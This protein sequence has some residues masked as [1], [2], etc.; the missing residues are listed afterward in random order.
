MARTNY[1]NLPQM[2]PGT[3][4][5]RFTDSTS[6]PLLQKPPINSP[7]ADKRGFNASYE[8]Q[9]WFQT[10]V[11]AVREIQ[12]IT[13]LAQGGP[14]G[15]TGIQGLLGERGFTGLGGP[16]GPQG[17]QGATGIQGDIG[18]TGIQGITGTF[19]GDLNIDGGSAC[20]VYL[21]VQHID[22]GHACSLG[23]GPFG[24]NYDFGMSPFYMDDWS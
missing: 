3:T 16:V 1:S 17:I 9:A 22:G 15:A 19:A 23:Y 5:L 6:F 14:Q 13:G 11:T 20:T 18:S 7:I 21:P 10:L 12:G 8:Y 4:G 2:P 24:S